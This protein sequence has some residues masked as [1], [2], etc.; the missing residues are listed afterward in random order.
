MAGETVEKK[1]CCDGGES[2]V[3]VVILVMVVERL[4]RACC[5]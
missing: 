4:Q 3:D 5:C 2:E 1:H